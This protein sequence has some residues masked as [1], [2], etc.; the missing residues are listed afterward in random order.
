M[1]ALLDCAAEWSVLN[2]DVAE[3]LGLLNA[4]GELGVTLS[5]RFGRVEGTLDD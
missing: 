3:A 5:T 2:R 1:D 4:S